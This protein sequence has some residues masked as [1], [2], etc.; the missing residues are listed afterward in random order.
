MTMEE[1]ALESLAQ[2]LLVSLQNPYL[3]RT[4][5]ETLN[6]AAREWRDCQEVVPFWYGET[7]KHR[8][9]WCPKFRQEV[10]D[11]TKFTKR[12]VKK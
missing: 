1:K 10:M 12:E 6:I 3:H 9:I 11:L 8:F 2:Y 4:D 5:D 7:V